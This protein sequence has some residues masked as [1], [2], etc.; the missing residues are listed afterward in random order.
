MKKWGKAIG[1]IIV[2]VTCTA[3][4]ACGGNNDS[5]NNKSVESEETDKYGGIISDSKTRQEKYEGEWL[6]KENA[7]KEEYIEGSVE[8]FYIKVIYED[9]FLAESVIPMA[10]TVKFNGKLSDDWCVGDQVKVT[11]GDMYF[12]DDFSRAEADYIEVT[13]SDFELSDEEVA[14]KP[15]IYLY[16]EE[17]TRVSVNLALNGELTCTYPEYENG[18]NVTASPDGTITDENGQAYNYLYWEGNIDTNYDFSKGFCVRGEDTASFLEDALEKL[19]LTRKEANEFIIYWLPQM[20]DNLYNI[21]SF[22]TDSYTDVAKL[23]I[24]PKPDTLIRVFM[25]W[26]PATSYVEIEEQE[27]KAP[28]RKGFTV[29]EW[30][31]DEL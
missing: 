15:V 13:E 17:E 29:V 21:I 10:F 20:Q 25:T 9:C 11:Y 3:A 6:D 28:Q 1:V 14:Y 7:I 16:P 12:T 2:A 18:W 23:D 4:T 19:G 8:D 26:K 22:Q 27:L 24:L 5:V 30:G 31:G